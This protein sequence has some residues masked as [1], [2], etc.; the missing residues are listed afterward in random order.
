MYVL[1]KKKQAEKQVFPD[2][3]LPVP[4]SDNANVESLDG[5]SPA[6]GIK[7][8]NKYTFPFVVSN[9]AFIGNCFILL[10]LVW[11]ESH[12]K[13][14]DLL[15]SAVEVWAMTELIIFSLGLY[16]YKKNDAL[17]IRL[18]ALCYLLMALLGSALTF[19]FILYA[20]WKILLY[21]YI[22][23]LSGVGILLFLCTSTREEIEVFGNICS[24]IIIFGWIPSVMQ[25]A[26]GISFIR[27]RR[28]Q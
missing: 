28:K 24:C 11:L 25:I 20:I 16:L 23:P 7:P 5:I 14:P 9:I 21:Y 6:T 17:E 15:N 22:L 2:K 1:K 3:E 26:A 27:R 18:S 8:P 12:L 19:I 4:T 10:L 13:D